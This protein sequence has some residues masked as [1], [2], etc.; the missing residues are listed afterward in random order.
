LKTYSKFEDKSKAP[1]EFLN[2]FA[3]DCLFDGKNFRDL[4]KNNR[5]EYIIR[6]SIDNQGVLG[7]LYQMG[8][9]LRVLDC[10]PQDI[11]QKLN[12]L[13]EDGIDKSLFE[14]IENFE[15]FAN[16]LR[17]MRRKKKIK[18]KFR[19]ILTDSINENPNLFEKL[20]K[21]EILELF[22]WDNKEKV[23]PEAIDMNKIIEAV[24]IIDKSEE[25]DSD[26]RKPI[27]IEQF[28]IDFKNE[29][30]NYQNKSSL[31]EKTKFSKVLEFIIE[32]HE[33]LRPAFGESNKL[34][35]L[36]EFISLSMIIEKPHLLLDESNG[37]VAKV[38]PYIIQKI[39]MW[40]CQ[41]LSSDN[42][43]GLI[44]SK[45]DFDEEIEE[46]LNFFNRPLFGRQISN[47]SAQIS[48]KD[49]KIPL[50]RLDI[51]TCIFNSVDCIIGQDLLNIMAKFPISLP[52]IIKEL[53]DKDSYKACLTS[54][55]YFTVNYMNKYILM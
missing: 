16:L 34:I 15:K 14:K 13:R 12:K 43:S 21:L 37:I 4:W 48:K 6:S 31:N 27:D 28:N 53:H 46:N 22:K 17:E 35:N 33:D 18:F 5:F 50:S 7:K 45:E 40:G 41:A 10:I 47:S 2:K 30:Y 24:D 23:F 39:K 32:T 9:K 29:K 11:A 52:L 42:I 20:K 55:S 26:I 8:C 3:N 49:S 1:A 38:K 51:I 25:N 54:I 19:S 36:K 44:A